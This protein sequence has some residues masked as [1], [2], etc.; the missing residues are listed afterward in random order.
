MTRS[1]LALALA[2]AALEPRIQK[3]ALAY[4][5]LC[6][7]Q[8]VW[9]MDLSQEA[10]EEL[11]QHFRW[12]DPRHERETEVFTRLGCI[13]CQHLAPRIQANVLMITAL[14]DRECPPSTQFAAYNRLRTD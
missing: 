1:N 8:R 7:Y 10:Y 14:M 13:D 6:D 9:E 2:C 11:R 4:P 12:F 3:V 5:F